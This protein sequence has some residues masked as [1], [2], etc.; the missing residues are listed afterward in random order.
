M[1]NIRSQLIKKEFDRIH[2]SK[3]PMF[4]WIN[5]S[6][7]RYWYN[8]ETNSFDC[9]CGLSVVFTVPNENINYSSVSS[10]IDELEN[11]IREEYLIKHKIYLYFED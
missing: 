1:G 8:E 7:M 9:D 10:A 4:R 5:Y 2:G 3:I 11:K 6:P